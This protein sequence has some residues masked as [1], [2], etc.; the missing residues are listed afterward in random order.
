[1]LPGRL[2]LCYQYSCI[3]HILTKYLKRFFRNKLGGIIGFCIA[4]CLYEVLSLDIVKTRFW[5]GICTLINL[6]FAPSELFYS[7]YCT[8]LMPV[9]FKEC[10]K[11][12]YV[13][14]LAYG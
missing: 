5:G 3:V 4:E 1:M 11:Y 2:V 7:A 10:L 14:Q 9:D 12:F 6:T 13:G 8:L